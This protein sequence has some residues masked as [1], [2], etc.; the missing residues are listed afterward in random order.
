[1][2]VY[3]YDYAGLYLGET[4]ADESPLEEGK[5]LMPARC[6]ATPPPTEIPE[7]KHPR[8]AGSAWDLVNAPVSAPP[9]DPIVK[10]QEFLAQ[11]PDV[12]ALISA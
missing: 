6:T 1:M 11:N 5:Y 12:A 8:W 9:E 3:Q 4:T 10:L 2:L 7:G